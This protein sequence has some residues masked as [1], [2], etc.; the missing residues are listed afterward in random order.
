MLVIS[1]NRLRSS[2]CS[3]VMEV[4]VQLVWETS[5]S[6][7]FLI[8]CQQFFFLPL[9]HFL[10]C[11]MFSCTEAHLSTLI[12]NALLV[13]RHYLMKAYGRVGINFQALGE[14]IHHPDQRYAVRQS[15]DLFICV[16]PRIWKGRE[17]KQVSLLPAFVHNKSSGNRCTTF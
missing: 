16:E 5:V 1:S 6:S 2:F 17:V 15:N 13:A 8:V 11:Q 10:W 12:G 9:F 3:F 7:F 14:C 4:I